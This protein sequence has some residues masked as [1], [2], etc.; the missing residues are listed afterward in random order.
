MSFFLH[1]L[2]AHNIG[3]IYPDRFRV[4]REKH[5]K[6]IHCI[7]NPNHSIEIKASSHKTHIFANRSY[8][9]PTTNNNKKSK[10]GFYITVNFETFG[11][12]TP[13][14]PK[15]RLIRFGYLEHSDWK[16]Q[17]AATGQQASLSKA[18]YAHKLKTIYAM[19]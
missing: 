15:I 12:E 8:A 16:A 1:E 17:S 18:A 14:R 3:M 19:E 6:D 7:E 2:I 10:D 9:Q 13:A 11:N 5:E 4:G